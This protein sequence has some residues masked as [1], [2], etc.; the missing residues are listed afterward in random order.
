MLHPFSIDLE[1][2][3]QGIELPISEWAGKEKRI[4]K[5]MDKIIEIL[6]ETD[7][8]CTFFILGWVGENYPEL[9]KKLSKAGHEIASHGY[10]HDKVYD[11]KPAEFKEKLSRTKKIL[12]DLSGQEIKGHRAPFFSITSKCLWGLEV[13]RE[14]GFEYDC[15]ISPIKTW[16]YGIDSSPDHIYRIEELDLIEYPCNTF[17]MMNKNFAIGGAYFRIFPYRLFKKAYAENTSNGIPTMFYAHP[18]EYDPGHPFIKFEKK[19]MLTHYFNLR[20]MAKRTKKLLST[21][22]FGTVE[23]VLSQVRSTSTIPALSIQKL[24]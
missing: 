16:R 10:Q 2:W 13:I 1:D 9:I 8:K 19:A 7:S 5:G 4:E 3:Y 22:S 23:E 11:M 20:A 12:E 15:S 6:E 18:W 17:Q 14:C 21:F 24:A